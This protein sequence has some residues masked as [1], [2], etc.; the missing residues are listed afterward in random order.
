MFLLRRAQNSICTI[1]RYRSYT[2]KAAAA[3]SPSE[4]SQKQSPAAT[5]KSS[6]A[7]DTV[8]TG[9]NYLKGQ[10]TVLAKPD[11]WYPD[12]LWTILEPKKLEYD[13]PGGKYERAERRKENKQR[14]K[15]RNFM[16]TQ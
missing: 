5:P 14:I 11:E 4:S 1:C 16:L 10:E 7:A 8:L 12:W 3:G 6:C 9:L 15:E 13:G 2:A